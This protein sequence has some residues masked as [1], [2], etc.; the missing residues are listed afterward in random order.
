MNN[1]VLIT[2]GSGL[3]A[4]SWAQTLRAQHVPVALGLHERTIALAGV[5]ACRLD[6]DS[7]DAAGRTLDAVAPR[8]VVH[9]A[10]MTNVE[11]CEADPARA[12]WVNVMLAD[13]VARACGARGIPLAHISTDHF[14]PGDRAMADERQPIEPLNA[15]A[16]TKAEAE[17]RVLEAHPRALVVRTNFYG[18]GPVY[19]QSFS[20]RIV[21]ALRRPA[22]ITLF[23]DVY[24]TPILAEAL[25]DAVHAL[26]TRQASGVF[27]VVGDERLSKHEFGLRLAAAFGL[28]A[29]LIRAGRLADQPA[30]VPRPLDMSLSNAKAC[31]VLGRPLGS[32]AAHLARL[33]EQEQLGLSKEL[34]SL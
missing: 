25:V 22:P 33:R 5:T 32:V 28:D 23:T 18:W 11:G 9:T 21:R 1:P 26:S 24:Y 13:H 6:L 29:G 34:Q 19:R 17:T 12:H 27:N 4:L 31:A 16:R 14:V 10:G 15:Y 7:A 2:G 8:L 20:E 30:L 3:L